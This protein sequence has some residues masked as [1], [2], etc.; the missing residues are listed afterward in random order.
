M[1]ERS[2]KART[3]KIAKTYKER[4][5]KFWPELIDSDIWSKDNKGFVCV[6]RA[7]PILMLIM[8]HFSQNK[9]L[10][11]TYF[12]LWARCFDE[13]VV[14]A[15]NQ[16]VLAT[17]A[18]FSGE[19]KVTTWKSRIQK[20][21]EL[22]FIKSKSTFDGDLI[23]LLN[24]FKVALKLFEQDQSQA[25]ALLKDALE[26]RVLEVNSKD[27]INLEEEDKEEDELMIA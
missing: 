10:S 22:G 15:D 14:R 18:G 24:P 11:K 3:K 9:P 21:E 20:L 23:V 27:L 12:S 6:P 8:D 5:E 26:T 17:E 4:R 7:M 19:R 25:L 13:M 1:S 16:F 2:N